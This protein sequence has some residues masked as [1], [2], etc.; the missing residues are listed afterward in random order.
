MY[1]KVV[2]SLTLLFGNNT[3]TLEEVLENPDLSISLRYEVDELVDFIV[4]K[5]CNPKECPILIQILDY[6]LPISKKQLNVPL[7]QQRNAASILSTIC[8]KLQNRIKTTNLLEKRIEEFID[9]KNSKINEQYTFAGHF[10]RITESYIRFEIRGGNEQP[11]ENP[12]EFLLNVLSKIKILAYR[13]LAIN[14]LSDFTGIF[15]Q[16]E[17]DEIRMENASIYVSNL[18]KKTKDNLL[19][20]YNL[21]SMIFQIY[22]QNE[23]FFTSFSLDSLRIL[24]DA[25]LSFPKDNQL[26]IFESFRIISILISKLDSQK[27]NKIIDDYVSVKEHKKAIISFAKANTFNLCSLFRVFWKFLLDYNEHL[28]DVM[29]L[30]FE[31]PYT[32]QNPEVNSFFYIKVIEIFSNLDSH[33]K[34]DYMENLKL[35]GRANLYMKNFNDKTTPNFNI[36]QLIDIMAQPLKSDEYELSINPNSK[37]SM[38]SEKWMR[39]VFAAKKILED[40][41]DAVEY[42]KKDFIE[43]SGFFM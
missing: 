7:I 10:Q 25:A 24:F 17:S 37:S 5:E 15:F 29:E 16:G 28:I 23:M 18:I 26:Y 3:P 9:P 41:N 35:I 19:H 8:N 20:R 14:L 21:I 31:D 33:T 39:T 13:F 6:A 42:A 40:K 27:V 30:F 32:N 22:Q 34:Y 4:P 1:R 2:N 36:L 38:S 12:Q 11:F 43:R